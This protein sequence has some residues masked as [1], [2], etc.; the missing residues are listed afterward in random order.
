MTYRNSSLPEVAGDAAVIV[1]DGDA[2]AMGRAAAEMALN[3]D[4]TARL[5]KAGLARTGNSH[6]AGPLWP[7]SQNMAGHISADIR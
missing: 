5:R 3:P 6:G 2:E 1:A 7:R 4:R